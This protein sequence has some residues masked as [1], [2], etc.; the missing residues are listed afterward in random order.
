[1]TYSPGGLKGQENGCLILKNTKLGRTRLQWAYYGVQE[2]ISSLENN[3][4]MSNKF[5]CCSWCRQDNSLIGCWLPCELHICTKLTI[6]SI[7]INHL[8]NLMCDTSCGNAA[9]LMFIFCD[10]KEKREQTCVNLITS[11]LSQLLQEHCEHMSN[12]QKHFTVLKHVLELYQKHKNMKTQPSHKEF[13]ETLRIE[14]A[15]SYLSAFIVLDALDEGPEDEGIQ[16]NLMSNLQNLG[17]VQ[18]LVTSHDLPSIAR[19]MT[20]VPRLPIQA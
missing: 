4:M 16:Q 19:L 9:V 11:L 12:S 15:Q 10:Y 18:L 20:R 1:M 17:A 2:Y 14:I 3:I 6:R 5:A 8:Q 13:L 7:V